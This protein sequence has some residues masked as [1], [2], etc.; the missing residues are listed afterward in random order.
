MKKRHKLLN[1]NAKLVLNIETMRI[2]S[3]E[4]F[5]LVRGAGPGGDPTE[6]NPTDV[7]SSCQTQ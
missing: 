1:S 7:G 2:L 4:T 3:C 6:I 5:K